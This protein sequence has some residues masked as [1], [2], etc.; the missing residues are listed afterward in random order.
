MKV[1]FV[2]DQASNREHWRKSF[3]KGIAGL[4]L[5]TFADV[6]S[7]LAALRTETPDIVFIDFFLDGRTGLEVVAF[8][9]RRANANPCPV[10]IAHSSL[11]SASERMVEGGADF[12]VPKEKIGGVI[13]A[14]QAAIRRK[15]DLEAIVRTRR[16][17][18]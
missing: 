12:A 7:I 11:D 6:D 17:P 16:W 5:R 2:D 18:G 4:S 10:L 1:W 13:P 14:I 8:C 15:A 3:S 9:R